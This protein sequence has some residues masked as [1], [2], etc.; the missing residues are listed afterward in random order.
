[1]ADDELNKMID[2]ICEV[3]TEMVRKIHNTTDDDWYGCENN[4]KMIFVKLSIFVNMLW[5]DY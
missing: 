1:M 3:P 5:F 2:D 4:S